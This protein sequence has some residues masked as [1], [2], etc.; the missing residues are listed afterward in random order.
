MTERAALAG[1]RVVITRSLDQSDA[2][3][4]DLESLGAEVV[5]LPLI[6]TVDADGDA[7]DRALSRLDAIDWLVVTS[8]NGARRV[9]EAL[10]ARPSGRPNVAVVGRATEDALGRPADLVPDDQIAEGLLAVFPSG[11]GRVLLAQ[12]E[13]ARPVLAEGLA[14]RG[15]RVVP[16]VAYR[17]V[18][19]DPTWASD[20]SWASARD[21]ATGADA[22]VFTSGSTVRGWA[23]AVGAPPP[24]VVVAI[25]PVTAAVAHES[26][27]VVTVVADDHSRRGI[28][29]ALLDVLGRTS[30]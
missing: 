3:A 5:R 20:P 24:A 13:S 16:V 9:R 21:V 28:V 18:V 26:G 29:D 6:A 17:T 10:A 4:A 23:Q 30:D 7:L 12:A 11:D 25:G 2:L 14:A 8:P 22:V 19:A 1:R 15:W 27:M